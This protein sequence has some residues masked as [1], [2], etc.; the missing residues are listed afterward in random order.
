MPDESALSLVDLPGEVEDRHG[1]HWYPVGGEWVR[2]EAPNRRLSRR[3]LE[4]RYG[5]LV[6]GHTHRCIRSRGRL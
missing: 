1:D 5:P 2:V 6:D 4:A 3:D